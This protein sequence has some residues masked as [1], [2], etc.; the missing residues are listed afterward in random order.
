MPQEGL[1]PPGDAVHNA[2]AVAR[3]QLRGVGDPSG[4][5]G[6]GERGVD[7]GGDRDSWTQER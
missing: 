4:N 5:H 7:W 6:L 2:G 3:L 1:S